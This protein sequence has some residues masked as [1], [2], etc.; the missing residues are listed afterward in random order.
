MSVDVD[1]DLSN[2][3]H[4][5]EHVQWVKVMV[6]DADYLE[7][8]ANLG[9]SFGFELHSWALDDPHASSRIIAMFRNKNG[10]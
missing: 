3:F 7:D 2:P 1:K 8:A 5:R 6:G 10:T 4:G 9:V